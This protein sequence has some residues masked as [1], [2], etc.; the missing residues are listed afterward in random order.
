MLDSIG[1]TGEILQHSGPA[2]E[3]H[4]SDAMIGVSRQRVH[5]GRQALIFI[6]FAHGG[7]PHLHQHHNR[8][9]LPVGLRVET[10]F[11]FD[12]VIRD[13][14][15]LCGQIEHRIAVLGFNQGGNQ[16]QVRARA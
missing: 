9:R 12:A 7:T 1:I 2:I 16:H 8:Y 10:N 4:H 5:H 3:F 6:E 15:V 13:H 14:K 11:L